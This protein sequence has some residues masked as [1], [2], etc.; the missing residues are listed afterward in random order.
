MN[1]N[2]E[3]EKNIKGEICYDGVNPETK[4]CFFDDREYET[5]YFGYPIG[6]G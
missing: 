1:L 3:P 4:E 5:Y 2:V 6:E